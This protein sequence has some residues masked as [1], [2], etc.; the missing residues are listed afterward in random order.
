MFMINILIIRS[1]S[2]IKLLWIVLNIEYIMQHQLPLE[3]VQMQRLQLSVKLC[4]LASYASQG[5]FTRAIFTAILHA[6]FSAI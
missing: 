6:I 3:T 2:G 5:P 1:S 4:F